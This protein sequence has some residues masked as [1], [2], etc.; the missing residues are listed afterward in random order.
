MPMP[1][2]WRSRRRRGGSSIEEPSADCMSSE[3]DCSDRYETQLHDGDAAHG[4]DGGRALAGP[5][6]GPGMS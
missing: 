2:I 1:M 6:Q 4:P 3:V 5:P